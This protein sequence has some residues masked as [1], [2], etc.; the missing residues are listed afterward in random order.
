LRGKNMFLAKVIG[1][2]VSTQKD[3]RLIGSK[4]L[5][6]KKINENGEMQEDML[7]AADTVGA[8]NGEIVLVITGSTARLM[9]KD[10]AVP[11]DASIVGIVDEIVVGK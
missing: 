1:N 2:V 11:I 8:G 9:E 4:L 7:V 5:I 10:Q 3:E 6:I